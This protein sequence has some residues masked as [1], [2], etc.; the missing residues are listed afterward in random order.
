MLNHLKR[1]SAGIMAPS[2]EL[3]DGYYS[4]SRLFGQLYLPPIEQRASR[5]ALFCCDHKA[6][7]QGTADSIN[8]VEKG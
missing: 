6:S 7:M 5:P 3:A 4:Y 1:C 8:F 2:L